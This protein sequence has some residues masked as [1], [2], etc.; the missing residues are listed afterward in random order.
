VPLFLH[1]HAEVIRAGFNTLL[2][3]KNIT[4]TASSKR[5]L[6]SSIIL[7]YH[8]TSFQSR[9]EEIQLQYMDFF[10]SGWRKALLG[11]KKNEK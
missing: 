2:Q 8:K 10:K 4:K 1:S 11:K 5:T 9:I 7:V 6:V 3:R